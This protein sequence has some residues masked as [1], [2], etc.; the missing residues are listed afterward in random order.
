MGG[1]SPLTALQRVGWQEAG[2][3]ME[4]NDRMLLS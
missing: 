4:M 3:E 1:R 2:L